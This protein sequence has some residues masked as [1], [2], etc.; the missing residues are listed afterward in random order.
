M[1]ARMHYELSDLKIFLAVAEEGNL[2]RGAERSHLAASSVSLRIKGLEDA[3]GTQLLTRQS[4]GVALT[5]AGHILV[6][7]ARRCVAQLEQMNADLLPYAMGLTG[8]VTLFA[9]NVAVNSFLPD[10]LARYFALYPN[11]RVTLEDRLSADIPAAVSAGRADVGVCSFTHA[12]AHAELEFL[13]YRH[14]RLVLLVPFASKL[15]RDGS[16]DFCA[17]ADEPFV[18]PQQGTTL[19]TFLLS[20]AAALGIRLDVRVQVSGYDA[21]A[22]LVASG[23]GI[24]IVPQ[25]AL[26][27]DDARFRVVELSD[28]WAKQ[29]IRVCVRRRPAEKNRFRDKLVEL[30]CGPR[31]EVVQPV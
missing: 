23:A 1:L 6:E 30:L 20:K 14:D 11:G 21:I 29:D 9:N 18:I 12:H 5:P 2:S 24:G 17:C 28:P 4:R 10:D 19:H 25:S 22:R 16:V 31:S 15:G 7:H 27:A 8:H 26:Q 13:P 3:V